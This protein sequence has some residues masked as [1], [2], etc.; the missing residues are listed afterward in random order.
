MLMLWSSPV[1][2][3]VTVGRGEGASLAT[4]SVALNWPAVEGVN[5]TSTVQDCAAARLVAQVSFCRANRAASAPDRLKPDRPTGSGPELV[6]V[7]VCAA[8]V[9]PNGCPAKSTSSGDIVST[10]SAA[11]A[12]PVS[13]VTANSTAA[14]AAK[15]RPM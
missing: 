5:V 13:D 9:T 6:R 12:G 15:S 10:G 11:C 1:P 3:S 7:T 4:S 8:D 2:C 14:I